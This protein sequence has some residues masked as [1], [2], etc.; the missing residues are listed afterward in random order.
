VLNRSLSISIRPGE[1]EDDI[2][3]GPTGST[4]AEAAGMR[5][6]PVSDWPA[7]LRAEIE[8]SWESIFNQARYGRHGVWQATVSV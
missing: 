5:G 4:R 2:L 7:D 3:A 8:R 6:A 1:T